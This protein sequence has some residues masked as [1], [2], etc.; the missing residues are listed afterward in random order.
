VEIGTGSFAPVR[1][2]VGFRHRRRRYINLGFDNA[3]IEQ[4]IKYESENYA[5]LIRKGRL[6]LIPKS[7]PSVYEHSDTSVSRHAIPKPRPHAIETNAG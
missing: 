5:A 1:S 7:V 4:L 2:S 6:L 3:K